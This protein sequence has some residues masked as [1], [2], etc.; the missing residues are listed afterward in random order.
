MRALPLVVVALV[1]GVLAATPVRA[2]ERAPGADPGGG[3]APVDEK[4][5]IETLEEGEEPAAE[6]DVHPIPEEHAVPAEPPP[7]AEPLAP[8]PPSRSRIVKLWP[9]FEYETDAA[10]G[11][12]RLGLL[13]PLLEFRSDPT[14]ISLFIRPFL[15]LVQARVGHDD[16]VRLFYPL[17]ESHWQA[18]E[19]STRGL[20][21]LLRYRTR[22]TADGT[23]LTHQRFAALPLFFYDWDAPDEWGTTAILPIYANIEHALGYDHVRTVLFPAYLYLR[24]GK[25]ERRYLFFPVIGATTG[26]GA[27]GAQVWPLYGF[28]TL[29]DRYDGGFALWPFYLWSDERVEGGTE[30]HVASY[31]FYARRRGPTRDTTVVLWPFYRRERWQDAGGREASLETIFPLYRVARDAESSAGNVPALVDALFPHD[32]AVQALY[33]PLWEAYAWEGPHAAPR[34][35]AAGGAVTHDRFGTSYP[36]RFDPAP[37]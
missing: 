8:A 19:Q 5:V 25:I 4:A 21:G 18:E 7:D 22:T 32:E 9:L 17:L 2:E 3:A 31:P 13:G 15:S 35:R 33:T 16:H 23:A 36:W 1:A 10:A 20:G 14:H 11:T 6:T 29:R 37:R 34:W 26:P 28:R 27:R 12:R 30:R 24:Q